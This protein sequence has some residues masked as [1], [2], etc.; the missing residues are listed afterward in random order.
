M[1]A[2]GPA[3]H[4]RQLLTNTPS[5]AGATLSSSTFWRWRTP[6]WR[7]MR[8]SPGC[9]RSCADTDLGS[10]TDYKARTIPALGID[11]YADDLYPANLVLALLPPEGDTDG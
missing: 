4:H 2:F 11:A 5:F 7:L 1:L 10:R 8:A 3:H 9:C 6:R